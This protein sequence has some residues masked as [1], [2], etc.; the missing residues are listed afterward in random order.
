MKKRQSST[1]VAAGANRGNESNTK[2]HKTSRT[3]SSTSTKSKRRWPDA[4]PNGKRKYKFTK[5]GLLFGLD[6]A[7]WAALAHFPHDFDRA[8]DA[9]KPNG[10]WNGKQVVLRKALD[11]IGMGWVATNTT[12]YRPII[13][14]LFDKAMASHEINEWGTLAASLPATHMV[15]VDDQELCEEGECQYNFAIDPLDDENISNAEHIKEVIEQCGVAVVRKAV[16][17]AASTSMRNEGGKRVQIRNSTGNGIASTSTAGESYYA[18]C[19]SSIWIDLQNRLL[20]SF[21]NDGAKYE[22]AKDTRKAIILQYAEGA[23]N[24][25]H[26]DSNKDE[27]FPYQACCL[28]STPGRDF[29]GGEFYVSRRADNRIVRL[30]VDFKSAGD[31]VIFRADN[32]G[33]YSHGMLKVKCGTNAICERVAVGLLQVA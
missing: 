33:E 16:D 8:F 28:L 29:Q 6:G 2:R 13:G 24:W 27:S 5:N 25:A 7:V 26:K 32:Q 17:V 21:L 14:H 1:T 12:A 15:E 9:K 30:R 10:T 23:E 20:A 4:C 22:T 3:A 18:D 11:L 19:S 31:M